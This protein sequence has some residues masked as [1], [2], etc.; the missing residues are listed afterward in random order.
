MFVTR[1]YKEWRLLFWALVL[2]MAAQAFFMARGIENVPFFLYHMYSKDHRPTDSIGVYLIKGPYGLY[3]NHKQLSNREEEMLMN[4]IDYY[5]KLKQSG[6]N[7]NETIE[8]RFR[9]R[10]SVAVYDYLQKQL[11]NDDAA[12]TAFPQWWANYLHSVINNDAYYV[13]VV[14]SY[15]YA[16]PPYNKSISDSLIFTVNLK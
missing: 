4:A 6:K 15:V 11:T 3:L 5:V 10:T 8:K 1:V 9:G 14:K 13:S 7:I 12:L 2:F 16:L